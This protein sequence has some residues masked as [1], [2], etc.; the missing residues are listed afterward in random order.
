MPA[1]IAST[2]AMPDALAASRAPSRPWAS[3]AIDTDIAGLAEIWRAFEATAL[4]TPYQS[5]DWISTFV[6]TIGTAHG[7]ALRYALVRDAD[8]ELC[9]LLPLTITGRSGFRFAEFIGGKHANYHMGLY[10]PAFAA[11]LD[12]QLTTLLLTE[13]GTAIGGLD[14]LAFVNQPVTWQD[15]G[16]PA[17]LLAA[18]PSPSRAYKLALIAGDGDATLKR[19]MSSHARKKLKNKH[20]R[21]RDFGPSMLTRATTPDEVARVIDAFLSQKAERFRAMGVPDP[22]AEPA[23]RAFLERGSLETGSGRPA[24]ELYAL[25]LGGRAVATYVG[26]IQGERFSGMAT[27]FDMASETVKTSPGELLLAELIRLK[28]REGVAVFDL[29]VG[30]ARY[31]TT[32]CDDHDDLVDS[33]LPLTLKGRLFARIA[34]TK[35]ELKRR[36]KRSPV[37]LKIAQRASGWLRSKRSEEE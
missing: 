14:A 4:V 33:F 28:A 7:M 24:I 1:A 32:F 17:A 23:M 27:S 25:D 37:A 29:G 26:A 9:A 2:P 15:V 35:R 16:N 3:I 8:G 13:I 20:S 11:Q 30:E 18:G 5:Y 31:K 10:A 12:A 6:E 21:F 22:F 19:S 36:I 34:R